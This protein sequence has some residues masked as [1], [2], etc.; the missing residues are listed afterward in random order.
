LKREK[1]QNR[2]RNS[3]QQRSDL[4]PYFVMGAD[5]DSLCV[6]GYTRLAD[7][8]EVRM[9][10]ERIADLVSSM[11]IHLMLNTDDGDIRVKNELS[12]K[13]DIDPNRDMTRKTFVHNIVRTLLLEGDGNSL[14]FPEVSNGLLENLQ[15]LRPSESSL[16]PKGDSYIVR[17]RGMT[18][19]PD[20]LLHFVI[21]PVPDYPWKGQGY[22]VTLRDVTQNL[23]QA[24]ATKKG[25]MESKWKPS[26]IVRV[27]ALTDEFAGP[28]GRRKFLDEYV[29]T[30]EAGEPW[31][32]P[33]ELLDIKE[34]KPLSLQDLAINDAVTLDK[35]TVAAILFVPPF[36]VGAGTFNKDEWN[37]F[38][39][40]RIRPIAQ[41]IEQ[42]LTRKLLI[43]PD[44][45]FRFNSRALYAYDI[46]D[47]STVGQELY[48]RGIMTGNEVRDWI[49][50]S[51]RQGLSEL[52]ILENYIPLDKIAQQAKLNGGDS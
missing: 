46:K 28:A 41:A 9:A 52:V 35:K 20:D 12:R 18:Y 51:P 14:V 43:S 6:S 5:F 31:V 49:S 50:M 44:L 37:N 8:P 39:G 27:D 21:N 17:Y 38:I 30:Q 10:T 45:Y 2:A 19:D 15:P 33:S 29:Q 13:I 32:I 42:E 48:V 22:R 11:T 23:K 26:V 34:V 36:L 16:L 1:Q 24:A 47:L 4:I 40:S 7:N 25:F 3:P